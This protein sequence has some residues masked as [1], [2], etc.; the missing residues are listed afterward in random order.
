MTK[1]AATRAMAPVARLAVFES[2]GRAEEDLLIELARAAWVFAWA[3][4]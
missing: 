1:P 2:L 4:V 3:T